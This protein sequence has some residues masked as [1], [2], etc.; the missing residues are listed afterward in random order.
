[1][2]QFMLY[3]IALC[4]LSTA[5]SKSFSADK[6]VISEAND[7]CHEQGRTSQLTDLVEDAI[8]G[9]SI[10]SGY[11]SQEIIIIDEIVLH[12]QDQKSS[13][14][15]QGLF[16]HD[17]IIID[18]IAELSEMKTECSSDYIVVE[19]AV[20]LVQSLTELP[21]S[22]A[23]IIVGDLIFML[24][25][26]HTDAG[27]TSAWLTNVLIPAVAQL[28]QGTTSSALGITIGQWSSL[29]GSA[30]S[31]YLAVRL[32]MY[33]IQNEL[34]DGGSK[35]SH[36]QGPFGGSEAM[37][38]IKQKPQRRLEFAYHGSARDMVAEISLCS[39]SGACVFN[40]S[41]PIAAGQ[42]VEIDLVSIPS[43]VYVVLVEAGGRMCAQQKVM[44]P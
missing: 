38:S 13:L 19:D 26:G 21:P 36:V 11:L 24:E 28:P 15:A 18:L 32:T 33:E 20:M 40:Q 8:D 7:G 12:L 39:V 6:Q 35:K 41:M 17:N 5:P 4:A 2:K 9:L 42:L 30:E 34:Q 1:M 10:I 27:N 23:A 44:M 25:T 16:T 3:V 29:L 31:E 22:Q 14:N 37:V 43:G